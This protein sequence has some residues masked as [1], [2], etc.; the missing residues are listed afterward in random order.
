MK[1][2]LA[3]DYR[4]RIGYPMFLL[5]VFALL[6]SAAIS[7]G[8]RL[9]RSEIAQRLGEDLQALLEQVVPPAS[10]D[11]KLLEDTVT[12]HLS[13]DRSIQAY[14]ARREDRVTAVAYEMRGKGY[15]GSTL[16][17]VMGINRAGRVLGVRV[18]S[19]AETPGLGDKLELA[20]SDW[21]LGFDGRSLADPEPNG[22]AVKKDGGVFDQFT[23]A[24]IT[25]R[26]VVG[27]VKDG[28]ELFGVHRTELLGSEAAVGTPTDRRVAKQ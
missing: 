6:A 23:G 17:L 22:W 19:H 28:L 16:V 1:R 4:Q 14:R 15:G 21:I 2:L 10:H 24:T 25:P 9:T 3:S 18:V 7:F 20:K 13:N 11:N 27:L 5:G 12:I 26:R 8:D